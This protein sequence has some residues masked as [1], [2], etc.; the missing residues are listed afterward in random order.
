MQGQVNDPQKDSKEKD[1]ANHN[2]GRSIDFLF[3][4]PRHLPH[5]QLNI[6][7]KLFDQGWLKVI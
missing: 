3:P 4:R 2:D 6:I 7:Q 1:G 5:F